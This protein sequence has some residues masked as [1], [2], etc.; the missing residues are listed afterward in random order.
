MTRELESDASQ[1]LVFVIGNNQ[2]FRL[3][4]Q[5]DGSP[6]DLSNVTALKF[7]IKDKKSKLDADAIFSI[8]INIAD[9]DHNLSNGEVIL[10]VT[11]TDWAAATNA[12]NGRFMWDVRIERPVG[13][14]PINLPNPPGECV[15]R[16]PIRR[17]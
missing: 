15:L 12:T 3:M 13:T 2:K 9:P 8:D 1:L 4:F 6:E 14:S 7:A 16:Y 5:C 11:D 17:L 10:K